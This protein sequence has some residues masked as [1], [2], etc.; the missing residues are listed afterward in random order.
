[1]YFL[2]YHFGFLNRHRAATP[3][4]IGSRPAASV[5]RRFMRLAGR[6]SCVA[7]VHFLFRSQRS[8]VASRLLTW[9]GAR[10]YHAAARAQRRSLPPLA[11]RGLAAS[12]VL[13]L[14]SFLASP[15]ALII[16]TKKTA[17]PFNP[18]ANPALNLVR[19]ALWTLRDKT[20]QRRLAL[21]QGLPTKSSDTFPEQLRTA[22]CTPLSLP[23]K[24]VL[25]TSCY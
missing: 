8:A 5:G 12:Q 4:L 11:L 14:A 22:R 1:M 15:L 9:V 2:A 24:P 20:E 10:C 21:L 19:F 17:L 18:R 6:F 13:R 16:H 25:Q 23:D 7:G 3:V